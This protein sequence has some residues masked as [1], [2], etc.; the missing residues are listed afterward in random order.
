METLLSRAIA[1]Y[2]CIYVF[3]MVK[4]LLKFTILFNEIPWLKKQN[5]GKPE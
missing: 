5:S 3:A 1:K 4:R 2:L